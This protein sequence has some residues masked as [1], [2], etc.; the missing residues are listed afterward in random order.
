MRITFQ[1]LAT[2]PPYPIM[3]GEGPLA[4]EFNKRQKDLWAA[5]KTDVVD[6]N[7]V[8]TMILEILL[9]DYDKRHASRKRK[10]KK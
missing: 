10:S 6:F 9:D 2:D 4:K 1:Q 8:T 7:F 5:G 3:H